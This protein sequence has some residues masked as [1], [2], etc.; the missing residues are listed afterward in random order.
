MVPL[1]FMDSDSVKLKNVRTGVGV[2][3]WGMG[4]RKHVKVLGSVLAAVN[5]VTF[6]LS[7]LF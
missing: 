4:R 7:S 2:G 6:L 3:W 5:K 1:L